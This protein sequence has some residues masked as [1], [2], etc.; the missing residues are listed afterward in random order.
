[1]L[2][3]GSTKKEPARDLYLIFRYSLSVG[4]L[5]LDCSIVMEKENT[6]AATLVAKIK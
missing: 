6:I 1:M 5:T 4:L 2:L 3:V